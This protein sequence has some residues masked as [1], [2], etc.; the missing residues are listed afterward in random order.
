MRF[1]HTLRACFGN[2][3]VAERGADHEGDERLQDARKDALKVNAVATREV[4]VKLPRALAKAR[5]VDGLEAVPSERVESG[6]VGLRQS[7]SCK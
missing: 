1:S 3:V 4:G 2:A 7:V 6:Q 5:L